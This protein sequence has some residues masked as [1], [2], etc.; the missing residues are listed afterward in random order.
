[1]ILNMRSQFKIWDYTC[2]PFS[3]STCFKFANKKHMFTCH[4]QNQSIHNAVQ[5]QIIYYVIRHDYLLFRNSYMCQS[6]MTL[7]RLSN[8]WM[9]NNFCISPVPRVKGILNEVTC[10][11]LDVMCHCW[12]IRWTALFWATVRQVMLYMYAMAN[13]ITIDHGF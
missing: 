12:E 2:L 7:I 8:I 4:V 3:H 5:K 13:F 1:M 10:V 11:F 9:S 6:F